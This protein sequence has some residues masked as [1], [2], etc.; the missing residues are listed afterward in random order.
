MKKMCSA[1]T[2]VSSFAG[3]ARLIAS[4]SRFRS[5]NTYTKMSFAFKK[6]RSISTVRKFRFSIPPLLLRFEVFMIMRYKVNGEK[7]VHLNPRPQP[8]GAKPS[9]KSK[10]GSACE[11]CGRYL[12]DPPNRFCSIACKVS[13]VD[14]KPNGQSHKMGLQIQEIQNL[15]L[16]ENQNSGSSSEGKESTLSSTDLSEEKTKTRVTESLK[17]QKQL[18]KRKDTPQRSPFS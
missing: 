7:A 5:A 9:T 2:V 15:S 11:A 1:S 8:K 17:P 6:C 13:A 16:K 10:S 12:E 3:I 14:V 18:N 4:T